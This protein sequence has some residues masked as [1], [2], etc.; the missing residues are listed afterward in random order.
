[1]AIPMSMSASTSTCR[2]M[3]LAL[4]DS[5]SFRSVSEWICGIRKIVGALHR[6]RRIHIDS[7]Q[8]GEIQQFL[9][10][11]HSGSQ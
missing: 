1:M 2:I 9:G 7:P 4:R 11:C 10:A 5:S 8:A 6:G 3:P